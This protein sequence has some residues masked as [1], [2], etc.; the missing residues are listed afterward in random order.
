M[1]KYKVKKKDMS[2]EGG[3]ICREC[4]RVYYNSGHHFLCED[5]W[6][7]FKNKKLERKEFKIRKN[8]GFENAP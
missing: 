2:K 4:K 1:S 3:M 6:Q 8:R 7:Y 5:C